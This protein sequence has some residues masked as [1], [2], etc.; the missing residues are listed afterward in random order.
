MSKLMKSVSAAALGLVLVSCSAGNGGVDASA[1]AAE[2]QA[3][4]ARAFL[5]R[6]DSELAAMNKEAALAFWNQATDIREETNAAAAE[7]GAKATKLAVSLAQRIQEVRRLDPAAG[8]CPQ[9]ADPARR[10]HHPCPLA[11]RR[12]RG[13][14]EADDRP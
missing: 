1:V 7:A 10:D 9:D 2:E 14:V 6:V 5:T 4:E 13:T 3:I 8:P 12:G 11:R